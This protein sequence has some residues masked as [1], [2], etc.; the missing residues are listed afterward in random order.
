M[1]GEQE[2]MRHVS[3]TSSKFVVRKVT[4]Y[5]NLNQ[6]HTLETSFIHPPSYFKKRRFI[7]ETRYFYSWSVLKTYF[8]SSMISVV[9]YS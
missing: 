9:R 2:I 3:S 1:T 4:P 6:L 5:Y 8:G 7:K